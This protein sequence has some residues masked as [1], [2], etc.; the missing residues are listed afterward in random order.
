MQKCGWVYCFNVSSKQLKLSLTMSPLVPN[1]E[2]FLTNVLEATPD[3]VFIYSLE[4]K[5]IIY[6]NPRMQELLGYSFDAIQQMDSKFLELVTHPDEY[7]LVNAC[8]ATLNNIEDDDVIKSHL[9]FK[10][11]NSDYGWFK[12]RNKVFSRND[13]GSVKQIISILADTTEEINMQNKLQQEEARFKAIY[14]NTS[15]LNFFVDTELKILAVNKTAI[16]H[17]QSTSEITPEVG[18][19]L[20]DYFPSEMHDAIVYKVTEATEGMPSQLLQ[21]YKDDKH[22]TMWLKSRY[23]PIFNQDGNLLGVNISSRDVSDLVNANIILEKQNKRLRDIARMN[24]HEIRKP[25][26]NILGL[27]YLVELEHKPKLSPETNVL[28]DHLKSS[29]TELDDVIRK[30]VETAAG[31]A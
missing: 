30:I 4:C 26:T 12:V 3:I 28:I 22:H 19:S 6:A 24:A 5:C 13:D 1:S 9:R 17:L 15:D 10:R 16:E 31:T 27:I 21:S 18:R 14:N 7:E 23:Y 20:L 11:L 29:S 8:F 2:N 25:L